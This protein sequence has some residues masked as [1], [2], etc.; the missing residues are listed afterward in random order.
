MKTSTNSNS[1]TLLPT[2]AALL[3]VCGAGVAALYQGTMGFEVVST[4]DGRRLAISRQPLALPATAVHQPEADTLAAMLRDDGRVAIVNF[5]YSS[6]NAVCTV[7]GSEY[8][9]MQDEIRKRGLQ[10][11]VRLISISFDPRD[12][13][14]VLASYALRQH[15]DPAVWRMVGIDKDDERKAL[16]DAFGI[17][18]LPAPM[19]EFQHNAAF[20]L[21]DRQGRLARIT[22]Y[23]NPA[24]ALEHAV[25]MA[26]AAPAGGGRL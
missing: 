19:G 3:L 21:I 10:R 11:D 23:D 2:L 5:I 9:Q 12:T 8:Q 4:E 15:A 17:V 6:C 1:S 14:P 22:D 24:Q 25:A 16:L 26:R 20:H 13:A 18:V 7:L